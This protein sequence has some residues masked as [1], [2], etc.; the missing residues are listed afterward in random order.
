MNTARMLGRATASSGA[1]EE[2]TIGTGL[3]LSA[4]TLTATASGGTVT[5]VAAS[6][7]TTG[8]SFTGSPITSSGTLTLTGTLA[9]ANGGTG[10]TSQS[11]ARAGLGSTTVGDNLFTLTNPSAIRFLRVNADNTVSALDAPNFRS[12]IG[13]GT[14]SGT[15]TSVSADGGTTGMSFTGGP[16]TGSGTLSLAGTLAVT[17]G[18]TGATTASAARSGLGA[19]VLGANFFTLTNPSSVTFVRI[20]ADNTIST[21]DAATFRTAIGAGTSSTTGTVTSVSGTGTVNGLSLSGTVTG[22]GNLTLGGTLSGVSL[23]TQV[24]GTLPVGNGGTGIATTPSNG[25]I[26]IGNGTNYT[27]ATLTAGNNT[28]IT[29]A[30]G[31]VTVG[32]GALTTAGTTNGALVAADAF[33]QVKATGGVTMPA[34][35]FSADQYV[36][37]RNTTAGNITVT[38]G[39][40]LTLRFVAL[41]GNRTL[42]QYGFMTVLYI[43][44][45]EAWVVGGVGVT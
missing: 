26:P 7:G 41:T 43:S 30:S 2:I 11:T 9:V 42:A 36:Y 31:S 13:A 10:G 40:S 29:N 32:A 25:Q 21:L 38:Q 22:S 6:G 27:A 20:N 39:G 44:A 16:V 33:K 8:L 45:T 18:G 35:V 5:S 15:V 14:G 23:T 24:S 19:T 37:I 17:N 3:S 34:N 4:G 28:A 1:I 12:A